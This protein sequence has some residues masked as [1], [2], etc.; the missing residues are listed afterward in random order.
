MNLTNVIFDLDGTFVDSLAGF[1]YCG[2]R[3]FEKQGFTHR[4]SD[5]RTIIG[6]PIRPIPGEISH[7]ERAQQLDGLEAAFRHSYRT[8][9]WGNPVL[10]CRADQALH[11]TAVGG[12]RLFTNT[13]RN[14]TV[15]ISRVLCRDSAT[16]LYSS[17]A[18]M[19]RSLMAL[20]GVST[21]TSIVVG[22]TIED[23]EAASEVRTPAAILVTGYGRLPQVAPRSLYRLGTLDELG[24]IFARVGG[25]V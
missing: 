2:D 7:E 17:K 20:D 23:F 24:S 15:R 14:A 22:D 4:T 21:A 25:A 5:L 10:M 3:A 9:G 18:E 6:P 16:Q 11:E 8:Q 12:Y 1:E 13:P 19:L